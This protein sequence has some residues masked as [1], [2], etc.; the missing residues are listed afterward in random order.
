MPPSE[1]HRFFSQLIAGVEYLHAKG[2][3]HRDLK[4]EN[5]LLDA[6]G[7]CRISVLGEGQY[8]TEP[9]SAGIAT[10]REFRLARLLMLGIR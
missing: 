1:A 4:P 10:L 5:L 8:D 7:K 6:D 2:V 3:T 9:E